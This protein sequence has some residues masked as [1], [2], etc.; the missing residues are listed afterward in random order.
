MYKAWGRRKHSEFRWLKYGDSKWPGHRVWREGGVRIEASIGG[1]ATG[2]ENRSKVPLW[3]EDK[4]KAH[5]LRNERDVKVFYTES[6]H[7][8]LWVMA[9]A[10]A[11]IQVEMKVAW[12]KMVVSGWR[13]VIHQIWVRNRQG[14][15]R[16]QDAFQVS[17]L[18][19]HMDNNIIDRGRKLW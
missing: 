6:W 16:R 2:Q 11:I 13:E 10:L 14:S 17:G 3:L 5:H 18:S 9:L 15:G 7:F 1:G 8:C 12:T 19:C 4:W